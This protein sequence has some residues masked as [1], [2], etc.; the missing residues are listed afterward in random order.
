MNK[1]IVFIFLLSGLF[2]DLFAQSNEI[3]SLNSLLSH[4][5]SREDRLSALN[6][7]TFLTREKDL[8]QALIWGQRAEELASELNDTLQISR[9]KG[10]LGWIYY[11]LGVWDKAFRYSKDSYLIAMSKDYKTELGMALN[12]LGSLFYRQELYDEA[13]KN[14]REAYGYGKAKNDSPG[15]LLAT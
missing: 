15:L 8:Q 4:Q 12:N 7:L 3:D 13:I 1:S 6:R 9:A 10:N 14:F 11:R 2:W 5:V